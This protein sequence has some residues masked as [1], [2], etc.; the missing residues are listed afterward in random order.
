MT[1]P[2][3]ASDQ[4]KYPSNTPCQEVEDESCFSFGDGSKFFRPVAC[5]GD[6]YKVSSINGRRAFGNDVE[7][8]RLDPAM[9]CPV[10]TAGADCF[11]QARRYPARRAIAGPVDT[12]RFSYRQ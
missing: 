12:A 9:P 4:T 6:A 2:T 10:M 8:A 7:V 11:S 3:T 5:L 1:N